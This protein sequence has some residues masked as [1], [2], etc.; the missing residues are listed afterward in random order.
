MLAERPVGVVL[1]DQRMPGMDG[2]ATLRAIRAAGTPGP[3]CP[4]WR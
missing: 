4:W 3:G 2:P 1:L